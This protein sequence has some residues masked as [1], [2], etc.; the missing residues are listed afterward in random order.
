MGIFMKILSRFRFP[1]SNFSFTLL[2]QMSE[3]PLFNVVDLNPQLYRR[4]K[5]LQRVRLLRIALFYLKDFIF[6][7]RCTTGYVLSRCDLEL[8][9]SY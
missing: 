7:C 2:D 1:V 9:S 3:D 4:V 5:G 8:L 6:A